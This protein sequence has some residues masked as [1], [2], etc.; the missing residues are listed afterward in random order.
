MRERESKYNSEYVLSCF[1]FLAVFVYV[2]S[3]PDWLASWDTTEYYD[4]EFNHHE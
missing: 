1:A 3:V 2:Y 4:I